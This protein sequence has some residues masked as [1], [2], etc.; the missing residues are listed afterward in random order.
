MVSVFGCR[1]LVV[2]VGCRR[3]NLRV[4]CVTESFTVGMYITGLGHVVH[5]R[6]HSF[7]PSLLSWFCSVV[8]SLLSRACNLHKYIITLWLIT[9][10]YKK[11]YALG[12]VFW[13]TPIPTAAHTHHRRWR[14]FSR[15]YIFSESSSVSSGGYHIESN[16]VQT[17]LVKRTTLLCM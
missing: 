7:F 9:L 12:L 1:L 10:C 8:T 17:I 16:A 6:V 14:S 15:G 5:Y 2:A 3:M 13:R 11:W 4:A